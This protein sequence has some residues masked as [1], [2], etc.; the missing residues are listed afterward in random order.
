MRIL[1]K[2]FL[3]V[4]IPFSIYSQN[5]I[6]IVVDGAR[7]SETFGAGNPNLF[8][9]H[10]WNDLKPLGTL[11][12]NFRNEGYTST[13]PGHSAILTGT[14]QNIANDGSER[15]YKP[16]LFEYFRKE[17]GAL[18]SE[19]YVVAGKEKL[20]VLNYSTDP[21][22]G[23]EYNASYTADD[24]ND[25]EVY[26]NLISIMDNFHPRLLIVNLASVDKAGHTG[27]WNNYINAIKKADR[28]IYKIYQKIKSDDFYKDSTTIFITNDHGRHDDLHGGF[29]NHGDSCEG[30][31]HIMLLALGR[32]VSKGKIIT[33]SKFQIDIAKTVGNL[34]S[35][36]TPKAA[37]ENLFVLSGIEE[38]S[39]TG[40]NFELFKNYPK[41]FDHAAAIKYSFN[42]GM[43]NKLLINGLLGR[44]VRTLIGRC[45]LPVILFKQGNLL[46]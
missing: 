20:N 34:L 31:R 22:Y 16:T 35:F 38:K 9:P 42:T 4:L 29:K 36:N 39:N 3:L 8:I 11:F 45:R 32:N 26:S 40:F 43:N 7:Y 30:C 14:W 46:Y 10:L 33:Q 21:D 18:E 28:L 24:L 37:G 6:I 12:T 41:L 19:N 15:P 5:V 17:I 1:Y 23:S 2:L 13:V 44:E 27:I 25:S